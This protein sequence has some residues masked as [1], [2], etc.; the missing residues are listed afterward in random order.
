VGR[1]YRAVRRQGEVHAAQIEATVD[2]GD[3]DW[4]ADEQV[5]L[6]V[7]EELDRTRHVSDALWQRLA[8][9]FTSE[10]ILE[11]LALIGFYRTVSLHANALALPIEPFAARFPVPA[12]GG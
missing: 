8:D 4:T 5:L 2:G 7:C 1:A 11:I 10:Q 6:D 3:A 9:H 12:T